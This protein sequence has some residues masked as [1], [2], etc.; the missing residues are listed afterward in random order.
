MKFGTTLV[1]GGHSPIALAIANNLAKI[2]K[3]C[4]LFTRDVSKFDVGLLKSKEVRV[5]EFD[6][7]HPNL[8]L[9]KDLI[10][11]NNVDSIV[12]MHRYK[13][14]VEDI[15]TRFRVEVFNPLKIVELFLETSQSDLKSVV[16]CSSPSSRVVQQKQSPGYHMSKD[17]LNAMM[18][19]LAATK[20]KGG[21]RFNC[22][23]PGAYIEKDRSKDFYLNNPHLVESIEELIPAGRFGLPEDVSSI[24]NFLISGESSYVNGTVIEV[25]GG[26]STIDPS[27]L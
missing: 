20:S 18:R 17:S 11:S 8:D 4:I 24:V 5:L 7:N 1:F 10:L 25:D 21:A 3:N 19:V 26:M 12:F 27:N 9:L 23:S 15:E 6:L 2:Q 22:V 13:E 14:Q 16:F